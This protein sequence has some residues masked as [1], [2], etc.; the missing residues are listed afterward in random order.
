MY[1]Y[2]FL[3]TAYKRAALQWHPDKN[4]G[5]E[6]AEERFKAIQ[7]AHEILSDSKERKWY[8]T[9]REDI[10]GEGDREQEDD[11]NLWGYFHPSVFRGY[12]DTGKV[13]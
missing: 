10:I 11:L 4:Q 1:I 5:N 6:E 12:G 9:H 7:T 2:I 3:A 8:D 13:R